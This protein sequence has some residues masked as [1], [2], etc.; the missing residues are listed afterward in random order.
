[1]VHH[2]EATVHLQLQ[3]RPAP[4]KAVL[5][6]EAVAAVTAVVEVVRE[7]ADRHTREAHQ[8]VRVLQ[9]AQEVQV[10]RRAAVVAA[11]DDNYFAINKLRKQNK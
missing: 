1:M 4:T 5:Q 8:E 7:V 6:Q 2:Q 11:E 10:P 9:V 3:N